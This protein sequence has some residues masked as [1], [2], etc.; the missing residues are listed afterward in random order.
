MA[1]CFLPDPPHHKRRIYTE[2][3]AKAVAAVWRAELIK[4]LATL[5]MYL[6]PG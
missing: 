1:E 4:F 5:A 2:E 3:K 6:P